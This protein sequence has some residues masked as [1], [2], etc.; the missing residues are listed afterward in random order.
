MWQAFFQERNTILSRKKGYMLVEISE[1]CYNF[2]GFYI[3]EGN[4]YGY[5]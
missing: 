4:Y 1:K 2:F 3:Q 5:V